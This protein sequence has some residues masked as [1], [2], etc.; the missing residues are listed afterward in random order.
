[1]DSSKRK[2]NSSMF[3]LLPPSN[4]TPIAGSCYKIIDSSILQE[5]F[6]SE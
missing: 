3:M 1:M 5:I 2:I 4:I 6:S